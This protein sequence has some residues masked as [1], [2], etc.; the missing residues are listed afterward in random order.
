[1]TYALMILPKAQKYLDKLDKDEIKNIGVSTEELKK[2]P[3]TRRA[4]VDI[5]K[6]KGFKSPPMYRIRVG[7]HRLQYFVDEAEKTIY[8][9]SAFLR[10]GDSDYR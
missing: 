7:R 5:K 10:S 6:L 4:L 8:V 1:M 2:N 9:T 3:Y